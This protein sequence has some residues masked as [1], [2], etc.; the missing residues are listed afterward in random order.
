MSMM[1]CV[2]DLLVGKCDCA[3]VYALVG[4]SKCKALGRV[5]GVRGDTGTNAS[6]E[7]PGDEVAADRVA[8]G[9]DVVALIEGGGDEAGRWVNGLASGVGHSGKLGDKRAATLE[10]HIRGAGGRSTQLA[11]GVVEPVVNGG[12]GAV[13][14]ASEAGCGEAVLVVEVAEEGDLLVGEAGHCLP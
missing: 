8:R 10:L 12:K 9:D 11:L 5:R 2:E 13:E 6:N 7:A 3:G 4:G 14:C 1:V